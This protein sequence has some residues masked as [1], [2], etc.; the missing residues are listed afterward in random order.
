MT[1]R[2]YCKGG[3]KKIVLEPEF[4]LNSVHPR[5]HRPVF[6]HRVIVLLSL[7]RQ[8]LSHPTTLV[9]RESVSYGQADR[10]GKSWI[11][12]EKKKASKCPSYMSE[13]AQCESSTT[14]FAS[15][16]TALFQS[17][18]WSQLFPCKLALEILLFLYFL[19]LFII[20]LKKIRGLFS[21]KNTQ[22]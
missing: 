15:L 17:L 20:S 5:N 14:H 9:C 13:D 3:I 8:S 11:K 18:S 19:L 22:P 12:K 4:C 2:H 21:E 7:K 10:T 6:Q 1:R 16:V